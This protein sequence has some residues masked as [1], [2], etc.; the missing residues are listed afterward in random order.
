MPKKPSSSPSHISADKKKI[1]PSA[2]ADDDILLDEDLDPE[3]LED[4]L[5]D[6]DDVS[7][8][9]EEGVIAAIEDPEKADDKEDEEEEVV[10]EEAILAK[11]DDL[12]ILNLLAKKANR[13]EQGLDDD[14]L[15]PDE[16][17]MN[18]F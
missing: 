9:E 18:S 15:L 8:K 5:E 6:E 16:E 17:G 13:M 1:A 10:D 12:E 7:V 2:G 4:A 14:E 11:G 3:D